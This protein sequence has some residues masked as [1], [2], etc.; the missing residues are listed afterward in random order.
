M[1]IFHLY[2]KMRSVVQ[3][4]LSDL[5]EVPFTFWMASYLLRICARILNCLI[6][7]EDMKL[8]VVP[9]LIRASTSDINYIN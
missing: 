2:L 3:F 8:L 6:T 9:L 7:L 5:F 4:I 1:Y